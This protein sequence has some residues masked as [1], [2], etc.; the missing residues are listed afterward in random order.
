MDKR[1]LLETV[2]SE[3]KTPIFLAEFDSRQSQLTLHVP[4]GRDLASLKVA[5]KL[6]SD[7]VG[8]P[9]KL[10]IRA[11]RLRKLAYPRSL[12]HWV[13]QF[14][15]DEIVYD[16]TMVMSRARDLIAAAKACRSMFG[17]AIGGLFFDPERRT[18]FVLARGKVDAAASSVL[19]QRVRA[20]VDGVLSGQSGGDHGGQPWTGVRAVAKLPHRKMIPI[21]AKSA[22]LTHEVTRV[23]RRW[24]APVALAFAL[25]GIAVPASAKVGAE[26][27]G[28]AGHK[29]GILGALSVFGDNAVPHEL[30][31]FASAGL[32]QYF[33]E[34]IH[35]AKGVRVAEVQHHR[36]RPKEVGQVGS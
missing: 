12:E 11:H 28:Q 15:I 32:Q 3:I 20:V 27:V 25:T 22:S 31:T 9:I 17:N 14:D 21:D 13:R 16:P 23:V 33:G 18:L 26:Q 24:L 7:K 1:I 2:L 34:R 29:F 35:T 30:D 8:E 4:K 5:A 36:R 6:A 19:D 10:S